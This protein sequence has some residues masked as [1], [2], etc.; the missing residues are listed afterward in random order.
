MKTLVVNTNRW[1]NPVPVMPLGA[2]LVA[3]A[4]AAAGHDVR[5]ADFTW[6]RRPLETLER[7]LDRFRPQVVGL[8][9]R[10]L[11]NND[12]AAPIAFH[13]ELPPL[14]DLVRRSGALSVLGGPAMGVMPRALLA[15][16]GAD[17]GVLRDGDRAFPAILDAVQSGRDP[18]DA[19]GV[20][21]LDDGRLRAN[22]ADGKADGGFKCVAPD[23]AR[24]LDLKPYSAN[25]V[26]APLQTKRG[27]PFQCV[28]CTYAAVE[29]AGY[30]LADPESVV[31]AARRIAAAGIRDAEFVDNVFNAPHVHAMA[32]SEALARA[33]TDLRFHTLELNPAF[34]D[35]ALV[36][37]MEAAGFRGVGVTAESASDAVL[38][39]LGKNYSFEA[40][41]KAA[42]ALRSTR[43]AV[44]W[45]FMLGGPGETRSSVR[46]TIRFACEVAR[47]S[48]VALFNVG[49]RI[50]PGTGIERIARAE[51]ILTAPEH[52]MLE[53]VHY[54]SPAV[55]REW[56]ERELED[57]C[58]RHMNLVG[59]YTL[60]FPRMSLVTRVAR[61]LGAT[62][63]LWRHTRLLRRT[64][65]AL[66]IRTI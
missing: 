38:S 56:V 57:A 46:E 8:S 52:E 2:C 23:F 18:R 59:P 43:M 32:V 55:S 39:G 3:E 19:P 49:I 61:R 24:W 4:A 44:M 20:A 47:P 53:P 27:C 60:N 1:T 17:V 41:A 35:D 25:M 6:D 37:A 13:R 34:V 65:A 62:P 21:W 64:L 42:E 31:E 29:G 63:P 11:D 45:I 16:S 26:L 58:R 40:V 22:D 51:G 54:F 15:H 9:F 33:R 30:A 36:A 14:V 12:L 50:Y 48:D 28:Y 10:N 66:G 5:M 7:E